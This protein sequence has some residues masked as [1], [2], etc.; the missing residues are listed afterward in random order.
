MRNG[1]ARYRNPDAYRKHPREV[2]NMP[3]IVDIVQGVV[4]QAVGQYGLDGVQGITHA[5]L[6]A[7]IGHIPVLGSIVTK[8]VG[9]IV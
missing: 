6:K 7:T 3:N 1:H 2:G 4:V 8:I 5:I 9:V